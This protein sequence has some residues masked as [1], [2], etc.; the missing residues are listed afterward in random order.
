MKLMQ[1]NGEQRK[2]VLTRGKKG[3]YGLLKEVLACRY[4]EWNIIVNCEVHVAREVIG[5]SRN[6]KPKNNETG[7]FDEE[8]QKAIKN[9]KK[10]FKVW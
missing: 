9:K 6:S 7:K 1:F 4:E 5:V 8:V 3:W 10:K 2:S